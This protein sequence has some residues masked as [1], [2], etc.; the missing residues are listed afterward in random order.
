MMVRKIDELGRLV[1]PKEMR[2]ALQ[3]EDREEILMT[4]NL[5]EKTILLELAKDCCD[6]CRKAKKRLI[7]FGKINL[8]D[9]C[10]DKLK[11]IQK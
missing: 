1:I 3:I 2:D 5:K 10:L 6:A 4:L 7:P 9:D 8:C 11:L